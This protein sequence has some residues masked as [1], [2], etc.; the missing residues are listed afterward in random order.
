MT[1]LTI[2][3]EIGSLADLDLALLRSRWLGLY[4]CE[5]PARMSRE[6]LIQAIAFRLQENAFG[7]LSTATRTA[8]ADARGATR[9]ERARIDRSAKAGTRFIREWQGRTVEAVADGSGGYLYHGCTYR[10]LSAIA[11][12]ITGTRWS[13]P[14]FFGLTAARGRDHGPA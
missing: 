4:A 14:A 1:G 5:A 8:I 11:R 9:M 2:Q 13:G 10:S 6:L 3:V 12:K 7:G